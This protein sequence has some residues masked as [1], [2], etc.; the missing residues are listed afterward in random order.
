MRHL[1]RKGARRIHQTSTGWNPAT[2]RPSSRMRSS[3]KGIVSKLVNT[4]RMRTKVHR[5]GESPSLTKKPRQRNGSNGSAC[6]SNRANFELHFSKHC[7]HACQHLHP[8]MKSKRVHER[9]TKKPRQ[10]R[11]WCVTSE[12]M[13]RDRAQNSNCTLLCILHT[14]SDITA[15]FV[16]PLCRFEMKFLRDA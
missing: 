12:T 10:R 11:M 15:K 14:P 16:K 9:L 13:V 5:K 4:K 8:R 2:M 6:C 7:E 3:L 1:A